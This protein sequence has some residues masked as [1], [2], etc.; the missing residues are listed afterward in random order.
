MCPRYKIDPAR[1]TTVLTSCGR[2][3]LLEETVSSF[4]RFFDA[5]KIIVAEDSDQPAA[6]SAFA[7]KFPSLVEMRV[8]NPRLGQMRSIDGVYA[9]F[10]TPWILHLE[11][12]WAFRQSLDLDRVTDFLQAHPDISVVCIAHGAYNRK[13]ARHAIN[14]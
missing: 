4:S 5:P 14:V 8:N 9:T 11:D 10:D 2:F 12:D 1:M 3:D 7:D 13:Y 6:A